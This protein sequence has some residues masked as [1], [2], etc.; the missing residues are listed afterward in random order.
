MNT[1]RYSLKS[2]AL[3]VL[4]IIPAIFVQAQTNRRRSQAK[5]SFRAPILRNID[6]VELMSIESRMGNVEKVDATKLV[7][8]REAQNIL[9]VW[10]KQKFSG[11]SAA[12]CHQPPYALRFYS[13]GKVVLFATV[14]WACHNVTFIVPDTKHWVDF[15]SDSQA[16]KLLREVFEK[17]FPSEKKFG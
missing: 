17:A 8:G 16:A 12:A 4:M 5:A 2:V 6:K 1:N 11:Y 13:K 7:E 10:R 14:C 9:A 3:L 15:K